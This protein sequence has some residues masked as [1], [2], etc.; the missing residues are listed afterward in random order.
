MEQLLTVESA[1]KLLKLHPQTVYRKCQRG[2]IASIRLGK[3]IRI[4]LHEIQGL[5]KSTALKNEALPSFLF[6]LFWEYDVD[7]LKA[8]DR[9]VIERVLDMGDLPEWRWLQ[10]HV[11]E[12]LIR[13]FLERSGKKRLN[14]KSFTF[15]TNIF[16]MRDHESK[17]STQGAAK[18]LEKF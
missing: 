8:T 10:R 18:S 3:T 9:I 11:P 4:P 16:E 7:K 5:K 1:A 12:H 17:R 15:W 2:E 14:P 6:P 13:D